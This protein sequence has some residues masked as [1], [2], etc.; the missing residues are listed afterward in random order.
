MLSLPTAAPLTKAKAEEF[1][2]SFKQGLEGVVDFWIRHSPDREKGGFFTCLERDGSVFDKDKFVWLQNREIWMFSELFNHYEARPQFLEMATLGANFM[3]E[4]GRAENGDWYFALNRNGDPLVVPYNIFSDCF[5]CMAFSAYANATKQPWARE[6]SAEAYA[7][8]LARQENPKGKWAKGVPG[9]RSGKMLAL[10]MILL[11]LCMELTGHMKECHVPGDEDVARR[12]GLSPEATQTKIASTLEM[13]FR[14]FVNCENHLM[15]EH[16]FDN[17]EDQDTFDGR[18]VNPGHT[19]ETC[20]FAIEAA[21]TLDAPQFA[22]TRR[23]AVEQACAL[24]LA[25]LEFGW[26]REHGGIFYFMDMKGRP[27]QQLEWDQKLWWVHVEAMIACIVAFRETRNPVFWNWYMRIHE[28]T[29]SHF[30]DPQHGE[31]FGYLNR[32]GEPL[33]TLKGGKWKGCFHV[34]RG[35]YRLH[36]IFRDMAKTL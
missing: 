19:L 4:H 29:M 33:L 25:T 6:I 36:L 12:F 31:W 24:A 17:P 22:E 10:P 28:Y 7:H 16:V 1:S 15:H 3:R 8:I 18:L 23:R 35:L 14:D 20:W 21:R 2:Q 5:A 13:L 26:D 32:Q 30:P 34:P 27:P 11:N 9:T